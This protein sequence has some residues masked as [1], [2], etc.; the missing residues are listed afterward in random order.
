VPV[1]TGADVIAVEFEVELVY[2]AVLPRERA[3]REDVA[4]ARST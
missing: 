3:D 2:L 1:D 4:G